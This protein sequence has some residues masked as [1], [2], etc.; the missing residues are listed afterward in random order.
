MIEAGL[1]KRDS[2]AQPMQYNNLEQ[3]GSI[4]HVR[5]Q[6]LRELEK[7]LLRGHLRL[8]LSSGGSVAS[9]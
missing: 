8:G 4:D 6:V 5:R 2:C 7:R 9:G 3:K 1:G